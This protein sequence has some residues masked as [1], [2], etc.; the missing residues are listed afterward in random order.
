MSLILALDTVIKCSSKYFLVTALDG[1]VGSGTKHLV[2]NV[3]LS[4]GANFAILSLRVLIA[5][6]VAAKVSSFKSKAEV[7]CTKPL[8]SVVA[9]LV[10]ASAS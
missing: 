7:N 8:P 9:D 5:F 3:G 6:A 4:I 2:V 10:I 1:S